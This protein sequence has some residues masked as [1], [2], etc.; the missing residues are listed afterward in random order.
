MHTENSVNEA[1][2]EIY[3]IF[4][5]VL[6]Q[7]LTFFFTEIRDLRHPPEVE[8]LQ[9]QAQLMLYDYMLT[10]HPTGRVRY[11]KALLLLP[12]LRA[13]AARNIEELFFR[14]T[15]G[16]VPIER[17]LCDMFKSS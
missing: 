17:L 11:G 5:F 12:G 3:F 8:S 4:S 16:N 10:H 9:E 2:T 14:K 15:I 6:H 7:I 1:C 13:M